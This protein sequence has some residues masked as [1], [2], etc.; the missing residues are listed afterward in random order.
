MVV[1]ISRPSAYL[2]RRRLAIHATKWRHVAIAPN[3]M[4]DASAASS[5]TPHM[6]TIVLNTARVPHSKIHPTTYE[7]VDEC[8]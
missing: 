4:T 2:S 8:G 5:G 6:T 7:V 1:G 3:V